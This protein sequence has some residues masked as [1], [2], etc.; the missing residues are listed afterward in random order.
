MILRLTRGCFGAPKIAKPMCRFPQDPLMLECYAATT[1]LSVLQVCSLGTCIAMKLHWYECASANIRFSY[2]ALAFFKVMTYWQRN[3]KIPPQ[4]KQPLLF[5]L[6]LVWTPWPL[7]QQ[8]Y[9][10]EAYLHLNKNYLNIGLEKR[11]RIAW[12]WTE[13]LGRDNDLTSALKH[14][15]KQFARLLWIWDR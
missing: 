6:M 1:S 2:R 13:S 9:K 8:S 10:C 5:R 4:K 3:F 12:K 7:S 15:S 14:S 11:F